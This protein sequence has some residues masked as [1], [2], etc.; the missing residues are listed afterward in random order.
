MRNVVLH[1]GVHRTG[2][3]FLQQQFFPFL[4]GVHLVHRDNYQDPPAD[5]TAGR[6]VHVAGT[7]PLFLDLAAEQAALERSLETAEQRT[8]LISMEQWFGSPWYGFHN[9]LDNSRKLKYL[10]PEARIILII[11]RQDMLLESLYRQHL[12]S[13]AHPT[14]HA[15]LNFAD[16]RFL[17]LHRGQRSFPSV[18]PRT[19]DFHRYVS[20]YRSL[21]GEPNVLVLPFERMHQDPRGFFG[22]LCDFIGTEPY[23][24]D[25]SERVH[26]SYSLLSSR[27]AL[28]LNRFVRADWR[29][30][31]GLPRLLPDRP[32]S[33]Y[34][35]RTRRDSR[36]NQ[37]LAE[38]N[39]RISLSY[40][41]TNVVDR[42]AHA[43]GQLIDDR[44]RRL[45]ME[46]HRDSNRALD[47]EFDLGLREYGYY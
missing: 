5:S 2:T 45:I 35:A 30:P 8:V 43:R 1:V 4:E 36:F 31:N 12:R 37:A 16:G 38:I 34:L 25:T 9:N 10:F 29:G 23:F 39:E 20:N 33:R 7:N 6:L 26:E 3:T 17:E 15:F 46:L 18:N 14:V 21:F 11:R 19:L 28:A 42:H 41:L 40:L 27:I 24:P 22:T 32:L 44:T 13:Y 47:E